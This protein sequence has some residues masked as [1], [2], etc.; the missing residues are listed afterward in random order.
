MATMFTVQERIP[1]LLIHGMLHL[2]GYAIRFTPLS[3]MQWFLC[4]FSRHNHET[5]EDWIRMTDRED[6][7]LEELKRSFPQGLK[8]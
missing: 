5:D 8:L 7:I 1:L 2:I 6:E 4:L 3:H